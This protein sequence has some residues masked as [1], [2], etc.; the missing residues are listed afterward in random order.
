MIEISEVRRR[1]LQAIAEG[2][3]VAGQRRERSH[4]AAAD[5]ARFLAKVAVPVFRMLGRALV[6]EGYAFE[7]STPQGAVRLGSQ[8]S[9]QDFLDLVLDVSLDPP[10][11]MGRASHSRGG[12]VTLVERPIRD[13]AP[14]AELTEEDVLQFL[15][16]EIAPFVER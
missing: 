1:L 4:A 16:A 6:A 2:R 15:L 5:Y 7:L 10:V 13:G 8:R 3:R 14:V 9:A 11:V 12:H